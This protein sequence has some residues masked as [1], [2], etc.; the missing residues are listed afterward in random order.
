MRDEEN[1]PPISSVGPDLLC[2]YGKWG[3]LAV[4]GGIAAAAVLE[5]MDV[6]LAAFG[7]VAMFGRDRGMDAENDQAGDDAG[8]G[9]D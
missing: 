6:A 4:D 3:R 7:A 5:E 8:D 2:P 1:P 9:A